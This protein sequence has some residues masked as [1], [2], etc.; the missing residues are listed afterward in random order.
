[1]LEPPIKDRPNPHTKGLQKS[2]LCNAV[3]HPDKEKIKR[4]CL[5]RVQVMKISM[6]RE[7]SLVFIEVLPE[8]LPHRIDDV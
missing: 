7:F 3:T 8:F 5:R 1:M 4:E 6:K 2:G